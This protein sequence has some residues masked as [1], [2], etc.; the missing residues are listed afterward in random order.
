VVIFFAV[1]FDSILGKKNFGVAESRYEKL[2]QR[3]KDA[4][5]QRTVYRQNFS[6]LSVDFCLSARNLFPGDRGC[7]IENGIM[8]LTHDSR[9]SAI[10]FT[11]VDCRL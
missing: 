7:S 8:P 9:R 11:T 4:K 1:A 3:R 5:E 10:A 2:T 6:P